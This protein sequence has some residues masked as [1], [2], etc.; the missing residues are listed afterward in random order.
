METLVEGLVQGGPFAVILGVFMW[1][2][3]KQQ[4]ARN[5]QD[6]ADREA[7][8]DQIKQLLTQNQSLI[9]QNQKDKADC[10]EQITELVIA[11]QQVAEAV[12]SVGASQHEIRNDGLERDQRIRNIQEMIEAEYKERMS[13]AKEREIERRAEELARSRKRA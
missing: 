6:R 4:S 13:A 1:L 8:R 12:K 5:K 11:I 9:I 7:D 10:R 2:S 3:F